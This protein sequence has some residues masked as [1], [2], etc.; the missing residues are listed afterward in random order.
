[1]K[2]ILVCCG[3]GIASSPQVAQKINDYLKSEGLD[4]KAQAEPKAIETAASTVENNPNVIAYIGIAPADD[5]LADVLDK[6]HVNHDI[7]GLPWMTGMG[8][9]EANEKIKALVEKNA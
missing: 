8:Q 6:Y 1:M 4:G 3:S 9:D 7:I 5:T 2:T